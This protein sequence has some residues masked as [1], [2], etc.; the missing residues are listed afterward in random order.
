MAQGTGLK[1]KKGSLT[2]LNLTPCAVRLVP[3][4]VSTIGFVGPVNNDREQ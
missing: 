2:D 4:F 1:V 3:L